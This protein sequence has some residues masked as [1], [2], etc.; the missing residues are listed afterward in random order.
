MT[1]P[2][3][4]RC[5]NELQHRVLR[6]LI[7]LMKEDANRYPNDIFVRLIL[8]RQRIWRFN[9]NCKRCLTGSWGRDP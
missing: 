4:L 6:F 9:G 2:S 1:D 7:A 5:I 3:R 8:E